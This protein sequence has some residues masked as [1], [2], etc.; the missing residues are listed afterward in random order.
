M[1]KTYLPNLLKD[2]IYPDDYAVLSQIYE[3]TD[4]Q[5]IIL[6]SV[7]YDS[8]YQYWSLGIYGSQTNKKI[9]FYQK[10]EDLNELLSLWI[11]KFSTWEIPTYGYSYRKNEK[12]AL[13]L[14]RF[15]YGAVSII[16][17][18]VRYGK[19]SMY[20]LLG[21]ELTSVEKSWHQ[22]NS[23]IPTPHISPEFDSYIDESIACHGY[24]KVLDLKF[25][26]SSDL[27]LLHKHFYDALERGEYRFWVLQIVPAITHNDIIKRAEM[28]IAIDLFDIDSGIIS[29]IIWFQDTKDFFSLDRDRIVFTYRDNPWPKIW[30]PSKSRIYYHGWYVLDTNICDL[31][32]ILIKPKW[33]PLMKPKIPS[34]GMDIYIKKSEIVPKIK[35]DISTITL[36]QNKYVSWIMKMRLFIIITAGIYLY[37]KYFL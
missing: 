17:Y 26:F 27:L 37:C 10:L 29:D 20:E 4:N 2:H 28:P 34:I 8:I 24:Y 31:K 6:S 5:R 11:V 7:T 21:Y 33:L 25:G 16:R 15:D 23:H 13:S 19:C 22:Y 9:W 32:P 18:L 30:F 1:N 36:R 14:S 12:I 3:L 35:W